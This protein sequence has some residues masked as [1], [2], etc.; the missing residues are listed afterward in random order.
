[1]GLSREVR[2]LECASIPAEVGGVEG[3]DG[4]LVSVSFFAT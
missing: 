1:M 2:P 3:V 4:F